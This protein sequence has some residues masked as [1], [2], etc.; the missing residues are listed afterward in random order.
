MD[1][2]VTGQEGEL[3]RTAINHKKAELLTNAK[4]TTTRNRLTSVMSKGA[5]AWT[6]GPGYSQRMSKAVFRAGLHVS[7]GVPVQPRPQKCKCGALSDMLGNHFAC[8][9][10]IH[11]RTQAH[12]YWKRTV[13]NVARREGFSVQEEMSADGKERPAD[14]LVY[15]LVKG[16]N[17]AINLS[18]SAAVDPSAPDRIAH[19]KMMKYKD[20][21]E[22]MG[23]VFCP[24][25]GDGYGAIRGGGASIINTLSKALA[26]KLGPVWPSASTMVWRT[27]SS[28]LIRRRAEAI[29][30]A[31][32][33]GW[34]SSTME[35]WEP[36]EGDPGGEVLDGEEEGGEEREEEAQEEEEESIEG[37]GI[38]N[39]Q[40]PPQVEGE[41]ME[42]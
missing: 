19:T 34:V 32:S 38:S 33:E 42:Q 24:L 13:G 30:Y 6:V 25:V 2:T 35:D 21:C 36:P 29:A 8:C 9:Q 10:L 27:M 31:W 26:D 4:D 7:L 17:A 39:A 37:A 41:R 11:K 28:C 15:G 16:K 18:I 3:N 40:L 12:N 5:N 20:Q 1:R 23:W 14:L 22:R